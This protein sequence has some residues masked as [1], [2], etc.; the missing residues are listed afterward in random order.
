MV[1][2][3]GPC[4]L[5]NS[6]PDYEKQLHVY[7]GCRHLH[8]HH[9]KEE[10]AGRY[11]A[12]VVRGGK[13][14]SESFNLWVFRRL[15]DSHL[16]V[17]CTPDGA[18]NGSWQ[19]NCST[20]TEEDGVTFS[21][22]SPVYRPSFSSHPP[23]IKVTSQDPNI[24]V[25]CTAKNKVGQASRM[26]SL[27]EV[28]AGQTEI[29]Y[30]LPLWA[31]LCLSKV[32]PLLLLGCLGLILKFRKAGGGRLMIQFLPTSQRRPPPPPKATSDSLDGHLR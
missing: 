13:M 21:W 2:F 3:N 16:S 6:H 10:D 23:V 20:G 5:Q 19:L 12:K 17:T 29:F 7:K 26:V 30:R 28:C 14:T 25:T 1:N 18:G 8:L 4:H 22:D 32:G 15:L 11:T 24:N 27:K 31:L 9:L